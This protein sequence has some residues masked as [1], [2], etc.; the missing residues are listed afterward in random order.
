MCVLLISTASIYRLKIL[1]YESNLKLT[2]TFPSS[3]CCLRK[4]CDLPRKCPWWGYQSLREKTR[5]LGSFWTP[6]KYAIVCLGRGDVGGRRGQ[7]GKEW[8]LYPGVKSCLSTFSIIKVE[9]SSFASIGISKL[10]S[11][12]NTTC[13][14]LLTGSP[15]IQKSLQ[16]HKSNISNSLSLTCK[17]KWNYQQIEE[18]NKLTPEETEIIQKRAV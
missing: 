15:L 4:T 6:H 7:V 5:A 13:E 18:E 2:F 1:A 10:P 16:L 12:G 14:I 3:N 11:G 8:H 17:Y 9:P